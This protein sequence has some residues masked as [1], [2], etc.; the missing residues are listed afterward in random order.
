MAFLKTELS[1]PFNIS[2]IKGLSFKGNN[3]LGIHDVTGYICPPIPPAGMTA[4]RFAFCSF[5]DLSAI[6]HAT[7]SIPLFIAES[8]YRDTFHLEFFLFPKS[9]LILIVLIWQRLLREASELFLFFG[10][11]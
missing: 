6:A 9:L 11:R 2:T 4:T 5:W 8:P 1:R 10:G 7:F 3:A